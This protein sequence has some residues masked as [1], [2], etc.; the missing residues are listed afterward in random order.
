MS[1]LLL[2]S[3][4]FAEIPREVLDLTPK[5][6]HEQECTRL[7]TS[8]ERMQA[9]ALDE[10]Q[11]DFDVV[12]YDLRLD[13]RDYDSRIIKGAVTTYARALTADFNEVILDLCTSLTIDS[14]VSEGT[15]LAFS[16]SS[17]LITITLNRS[18]AIDELFAVT[19]YYHGTP[20]QT[21]LYE[22]FDYWNRYVSGA[23]IPSIATLSEPYG[24]RDWWPGK[25]TPSD[26]ADSARIAITV[27]DTIVATSN[28][29]LESLTA[30]PP[31][32]RTYT[33]FEKHP[34]SSYLICMS[35]TN[36]AQWNDW[37]VF[38]ADDSMPIVNYVYPERLS[39]SLISWNGIPEILGVLEDLFGEYAFRDEKY[40]QTMFGWG[41]AM[42]HQCNT[43]YGY[44]LTN[45]N[46]AYD[47]IIA[48]EAAHQW[49]GDDV[50]LDTWP[51]IWLNE[52][53]ASYAEALWTEHE[54]GFSAYK[55]YMA[56][57]LS[58]NDPSGPVYN[59]SAL[60]DGNTVYD[61]GGWL[62]HILRGVVRDD[63]LFFA[64]LAEYRARH[65]YGTATTDEFL[66]DFSDV[67]G[68]D[69]T[70]YLYTFLYRTNRP[71]F[72]TA[73]GNGSVDGQPMTAVR[74]SQIQSNPDTT[75]RSRIELRFSGALDSTVI[76]E[77][78]D[79]E[80]VYL[81]DLGYAPTSLSV[82]PDVWILRTL[83]TASLP[84]TIL[85]PAV[86]AGLE[87]VAYLDT[88][89]AI[90]GTAPY[91]W[92]LIGGI[93]PNGVT[94]T[95]AGV[96]TG[97]PT[98]YGD[99]PFTALVLDNDTQA[100]MREFILSVAGLLEIPEALTCRRTADT[101]VTLSWLPANGADYYEIYRSDTGDFSGL[102]PLD[103]TPDTFFVDTIPTAD[104]IRFYQVVS[105]QSE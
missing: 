94:L 11:A 80:S 10:T 87:G 72:R 49:W 50:T 65:H 71:Q 47:Y 101:E 98:E 61:K 16:H 7:K 4:T 86:D 62:L 40:G 76:V 2:C 13:I 30:V 15:H 54:Q 90:G 73:W 59:P 42:E 55:S 57:G 74:I 104:A 31:S 28:G 27:A 97:T 89:V 19:V 35:A 48:H 78:S 25:N 63:P 45:G 93:L 18:Y 20:C 66:S 60:F 23:F 105:A 6:F 67:V 77:N 24:A 79:W 88:L 37:F 22:T 84:P 51:D 52:G 1:L 70:P 43:T 91:S 96:L 41:G 95:A 85:N 83:S 9:N 81:F 36:Y 64:A 100:D 68:Y 32:S 102:S 33:W 34:I 38:A 5:Q 53:F 3:L 39:Q 44:S 56:S 75:F 58:V 99:F 8:L 26:K 12:Y 92:S 29:V 21:N 69:V 46:H 103:T 14:I 82:D 17:N